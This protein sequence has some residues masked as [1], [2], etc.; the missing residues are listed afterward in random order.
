LNT[1]HI[2]AKSKTTTNPQYLLIYSKPHE[3]HLLFFGTCTKK[4]LK[5]PLQVR[6]NSTIEGSWL[7][8]LWNQRA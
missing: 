3:H 5:T 6:Q 7:R 1:Y 8:Y 2:S 4:P